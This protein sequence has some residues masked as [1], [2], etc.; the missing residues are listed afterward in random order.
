M[1][2]IRICFF[3]NQ[4]ERGYNKNKKQNQKNNHKNLFQK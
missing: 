1:N 3:F 4:R 2:E